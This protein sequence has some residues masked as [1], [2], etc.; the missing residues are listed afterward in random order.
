MW[1]SHTIECNL[2]IK[3]MN[4]ENMLSKRSQTHLKGHIL[5]SSIYIKSPKEANT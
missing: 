5:N 4:I 1:N 2:A 3:R